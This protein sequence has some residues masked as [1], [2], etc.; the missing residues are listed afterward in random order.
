MSN[1]TIEHITALLTAFIFASIVTPAQAANYVKKATWVESMIATRDAMI[2][3]RPPSKDPAGLPDMSKDSY[4]VA[5]WVKTKRGGTIF[6]KCQP[7]RSWQRRGKTIF[8]AGGRV[9]W[10]YTR[11]AYSTELQM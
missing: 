6:A 10:M 3:K 2:G 9:T 11:R 7:N 1:R 4:T 5:A 8:I